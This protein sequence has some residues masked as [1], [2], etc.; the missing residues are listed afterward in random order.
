MQYIRKANYATFT[1]EITLADGTPDDFSEA[2]LKFIV[3]KNKTDADESAVLLDV[4]NFPD[5]NIVSF[6]F[7]ADQTSGLE[8]GVYYS[9]LKVF[10]ANSLNYEIWSDKLTVKRETFN[11]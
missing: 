9:A 4:I 11:D 8:E 10:K 3:K 5:T 7:D 2:S 1:F 6:Q